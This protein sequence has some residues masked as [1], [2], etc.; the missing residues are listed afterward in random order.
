MATVPPMSGRVDFREDEVRLLEKGAAGRAS[1]LKERVADMDQLG[2]AIRERST[3][4]PA[5][6]DL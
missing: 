2:N 3:L 1:L 5:Q 6:F 4:P